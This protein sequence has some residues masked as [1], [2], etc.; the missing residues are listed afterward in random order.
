MD[1]L[2]DVLSRR[3]TPDDIK[4]AF[5]NYNSYLESVR[6]DLPASAYDCAVASWHYNHNDHRCPHDSWLESFVVS[7]IPS[8]SRA[9]K[10]EIAIEMRLFGA[11]HDG[12]LKLSYPGV[13]SYEFSSKRNPC[14]A[15][16]G[17]WLADEI[18]LS[19]CNLVLHEILFSSGSRWTIESGD[20]LVGWEPGIIASS[21]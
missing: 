21:S 20:I 5:S 3:S 18:R 4:N 15:G 11:Y 16:H 17:D 10:R 12:S 1:F 14:E 8:G 19:E 13:R 7:E 9:E 2:F 6:K